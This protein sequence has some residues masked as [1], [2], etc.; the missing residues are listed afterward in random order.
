MYRVVGSLLDENG[1]KRD[2]C[3]GRIWWVKYV[4][5]NRCV[6]KDV[7]R[8]KEPKWNFDRKHDPRKEQNSEDMVG[9]LLGEV[10]RDVKEMHRA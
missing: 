1:K 9:W 7:V 8:K 3:E 2:S 10:E 5:G 4:T 6:E